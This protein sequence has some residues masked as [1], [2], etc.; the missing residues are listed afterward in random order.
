VKQPPAPVPV[1][2]EKTV[3]ERPPLDPRALQ[4]AV[5]K[6]KSYLTGKDAT[7]AQAFKIEEKAQ[8]PF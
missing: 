2:P 8:M 3:E 1:K 7:L 5:E 4:A 6:I